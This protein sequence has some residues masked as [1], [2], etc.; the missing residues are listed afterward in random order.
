MM[1]SIYSILSLFSKEFKTYRDH[2]HNHY[3]RIQ[4][5]HHAPEDETEPF[6][7]ELNDNPV[8][9]S[10]GP[11]CGHTR[12]KFGVAYEDEH[13]RLKAPVTLL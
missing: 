9:K 8:V 4:M 2:S 10:I 5:A 3:W 12:D 7:I 13:K 6:V 1:G 11:E